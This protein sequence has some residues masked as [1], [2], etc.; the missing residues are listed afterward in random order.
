MV[1][2][3]DML[4]SQ[5]DGA[6]DGVVVV[7]Y[8]YHLGGLLMRLSWSR[9]R[10]NHRPVPL[11]M[12]LNIYTHGCWCGRRNVEDMRD[13]RGKRRKVWGFDVLLGCYRMLG[14]RTHQEAFNSIMRSYWSWYRARFI[15]DNPA[16]A[17]CG[18]EA[19]EVDHTLAISLGGSMWDEGNHQ[20]LCVSCHKAKTAEDRA[21]LAAARRLRSAVGTG[22][23]LDGPLG[24]CA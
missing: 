6:I 1:S 12:I 2:V 7:G 17:A 3:R 22:V 13:R 10:D 5:L 8:Q 11:W 9:G 20:P 18:A 4:V 23:G 15:R 24:W 21:K 19:E 16:C 14:D